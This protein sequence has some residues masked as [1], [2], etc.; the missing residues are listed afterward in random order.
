M[1]LKKLIT[2][3]LAPMLVVPM[4]LTPITAHGAGVTLDLSEAGSVQE[5]S[6]LDTL[7]EV[8][9]YLEAY[10]IEGADR[11]MFLENAI[12]GMVYTLDDPYS[13]Y[14]SVEELEEFEG[15]LNQEY[16]GIG[17]TLRFTNDQL[18]VTQPLPGSPALA[19]GIQQGDIISKVDGV[20]VTGME[21]IY[22]IQGIEGTNVVLEVLRGSKPMTF[23]ITRGHF[24]VPAV[25][26]KYFPDSKVGYI[27]L[28]SF[29]EQS[30]K[31]FAAE[32]GMLRKAGMESL[33]LDLRDNTGGYVNAAINIAKNFITNGTV[34]YTSGQSGKLEP[35][36]IVD[37]ESLDIPVIILTNEMTA[38]ASEILT[39]ALQD[40]NIATV[41][42][43]A[44]YG[45]ARIQNLFPLSNGSSLKLTVQKYLT[46]S[47][48][49]FNH[50]GLTPDIE[51]KNNAV[52]QLVL[53]L[54]L[55]GMQS[56][57]L[58]GSSSSLA[59]NGISVNGYIDVVQSGDKLYIP[60][61][62]LNALVNG[63]VVWSS[64]LQKVTITTKLGETAGFTVSSNAAKIINNETYVEI[65]QFQ[66]KFSGLKWSYQQGTITL[67]YK[68]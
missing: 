32:L 62:V 49:D 58:K 43:T 47:R 3:L 24:T 11:E 21:D 17:V 50:V 18:V 22:R 37:G 9:D 66:N 34:M 19:A 2:A 15:S 56:L 6:E 4:M 55:A 36:N 25:T 5:S 54:R 38:S 68:E 14:Y 44:T 63:E 60:S 41:V 59:I 33:V 51:V 16:V 28:S 8:L 31:Q 30:D 13:D 46:P 26:G 10:N 23:T 1:K 42:G 12:R 52:A 64:N 35:I 57:E 61:R 20:K 67:S 65:H 29:T 40:N 39:G 7:L 48:K 53:A 45:K 27:S